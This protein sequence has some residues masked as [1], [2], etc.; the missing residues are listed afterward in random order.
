MSC[1]QP[2]RDD[3]ENLKLHSREYV[4]VQSLKGLNALL[5]AILGYNT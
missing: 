4:T 1:L 3:A 2:L 5:F